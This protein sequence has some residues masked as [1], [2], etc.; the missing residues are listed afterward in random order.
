MGRAPKSRLGS[1]LGPGCRKRASCIGRKESASHAESTRQ[2]NHGL[3]GA[4]QAALSTVLTYGI[5]KTVSCGGSFIIF[6][7]QVEKQTR[8]GSV[9]GP[10]LHG[11]KVVGLAARSQPVLYSCTVQYGSHRPHVTRP[12]S[13]GLYVQTTPQ[14]SKGLGHRER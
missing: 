9:T 6:V 7:V 2:H 3:R 12:S 5:L 11:W 1:T 14:I 10:Q 13:D 8:R 4:R